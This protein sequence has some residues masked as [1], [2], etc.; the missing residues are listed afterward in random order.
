M[1]GELIAHVGAHRHRC[2]VQHYSVPNNGNIAA[3][4]YS[5]MPKPE[6]IA[7]ASGVLILSG[8]AAGPCSVNLEPSTTTI[9][10]GLTE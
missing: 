1:A 5:E 9:L 4:F 2:L 8:Q 3:G 10:G 7:R 6:S